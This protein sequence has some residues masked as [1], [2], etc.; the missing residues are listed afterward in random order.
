MSFLLFSLTK[1]KAEALT[2]HRPD[3]DMSYSALMWRIFDIFSK[4]I[5][6]I[7]DQY[8][9]YL[10]GLLLPTAFLQANIG[11]ALSYTKYGYITII[12]QLNYRLLY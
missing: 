10:L 4:F 9:R 7:L 8:L 11:H 12:V 3:S 6:K 5:L 1:Y 2:L